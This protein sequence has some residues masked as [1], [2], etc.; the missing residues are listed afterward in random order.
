L[1]N[2]ISPISDEVYPGNSNSLKLIE[3]FSLTFSCAM[4]L[5]AYPFDTQNCIFLIRLQDVPND[6]VKL[7]YSPTDGVSY[8][9]PQKLR[10]YGVQ[11]VSMFADDRGNYSGMGIGIFLENLSGF[12]VSTTYVPTFLMVAICY[13]TFYYSMDDFNDRIMVSLTAL[14]VLATL[15][16]QI[17]QTTPQTS[18]LKLLDVW[19][20]STILIDFFVV[21]ILVTINFFRLREEG[22]EGQE[23]FNTPVMSLK[24]NSIMK[25][26]EKPGIRFSE[27]LNHYA[28]WIIPL[29][30][31]I[32]VFF[33]VII[34]EWIM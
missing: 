20:V 15:F 24:Q 8:M 17:T 1:Y 29:L 16:T 5:S 2:N 28:R 23:D 3:S 11:S 18:Y 21:M 27:R 6:F 9:G 7:K 30:V 19:F 13:S 12:H 34:S 31:A 33:Y 22:E 10:E 4:N 26:I 14:L 25:S 32:F